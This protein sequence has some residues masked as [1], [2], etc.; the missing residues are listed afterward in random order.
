MVYNTSRETFPSNLIA[1]SF[2]FTAA[3]LFIVEKP[4]EKEAVKVSFT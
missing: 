3:A 2:N 4:E 1:N